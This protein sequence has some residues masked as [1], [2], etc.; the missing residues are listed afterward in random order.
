MMAASMSIL[1]QNSEKTVTLIDIPA[2]ISHAQG[3]EGSS[4]ELQLLSRSPIETPFVVQ[5]EPRKGKHI[6]VNT[7]EEEFHS[8]IKALVIGAL[9]EIKTG[10]TGSWCAPRAVAPSEEAHCSRKRKISQAEKP[11][12]NS[13]N[14]SSKGGSSSSLWVGATCE[15]SLRLNTEET[16]SELVLRKSR[17]T[18]HGSVCF[19]GLSDI[20]NSPFHNAH[21]ETIQ[22]HL[23]GDSHPASE[24]FYIPSNSTFLLSRIEDSISGFKAASALCPSLQTPTAGHGQ[25]DFV[26]LDPPWPNASAKRAR[27]YKRIKTVH[28]TEQ[29]LL[30]MQLEEHIAPSGYVGIWI[31]NKPRIRNLFLPRDTD[32]EHN[33]VSDH[34]LDQGEQR[35]LRTSLFESWGVEWAEEW[36]WI[37]TTRHGEPVTDLDSAWRKPYEILLLA[38]KKPL[39]TAVS[40]STSTS[41]ALPNPIRQQQQQRP[42]KRRVIAAVPDL[43]SRKPSVKELIEPFM[44]PPAPSHPDPSRKPGGYRALEVFARHL[45]AGWW[46]WGDEVLKFNWSG[47]WRGRG[48]SLAY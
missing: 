10:H 14:L 17:L 20:Y 44:R 45:T 34:D 48:A 35:K 42:I 25:F 23:A 27:S 2:S 7:V 26:L 3:L 6:Q 32:H 39:R 38:E 33:T 31:T 43:H 13:I 5:N 15:P 16:D 24:A 29:L 8:L 28:D 47:A 19:R 4:C 1:Y 37:K 22:L 30:S 9:E 11:C 40:T 12:E 18:A 46:S 41:S 21:T 36:I